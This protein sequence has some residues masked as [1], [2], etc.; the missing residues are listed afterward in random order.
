MRNQIAEG[1]QVFVVYPLIKESEKMDLLDLMAGYDAM[2][3][4]F[5]LPEYA[6]SMVHGK[7]KV[8]EKEYEMQRF[9]KGETCIML[10]T[11][12]IEVGID[13]PN[14][15]VMLVENAE[16]FGLS[17]LH[18]L[19]GRVGRGGEQSYCILM[20]GNK[21]TTESKQRLSAMVNTN[22][23]FEIANIDLR[24]RGPGDIQGTRQS[25]M[26]DFKIADLVKDEKIV[27][28]TRRLAQELL[29]TDPELSQPQNLPIK[30]F[31]DQMLKEYVYYGMIS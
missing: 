10:S 18:Q 19:R 9:V 7:M 17:Q 29:Q 8:D 24:L 14:A 25:G 30:K 23:G 16:R 12:V 13:V 20:S 11:T 31:L 15:T 22:D 21:L 26:L 3:L 27:S 4:E 1:R 6:I 28:Y 5:P 2:A